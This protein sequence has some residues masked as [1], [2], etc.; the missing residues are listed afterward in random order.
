MMNT[1]RIW[2]YLKRKSA[3]HTQGG[4]IKND[5]M[6]AECT[7]RRDPRWYMYKKKEREKKKRAQ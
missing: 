3:P 1:W 5:K 6:A 7:E 2:E 4:N